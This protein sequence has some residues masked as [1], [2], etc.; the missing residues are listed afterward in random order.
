MYPIVDLKNLSPQTQYDEICYRL[1]GADEYPEK[2]VLVVFKANRGLVEAARQ[3]R[4]WEGTEW[5]LAS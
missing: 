3:R 1:D 4:Q 5:E 2:A